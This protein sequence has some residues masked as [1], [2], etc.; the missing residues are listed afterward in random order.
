MKLKSYRKIKDDEGQV[1]IV[2]EAIKP[3]I[4]E[5][6]DVCRDANKYDAEQVIPN[7]SDKKQDPLYKHLE[8]IFKDTRSIVWVIESAQP[9][10]EFSAYAV[11]IFKKMDE[12]KDMFEEEGYLWVNKALGL[13]ENSKTPHWRE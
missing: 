1:W 5:L 9:T 4:E 7:S 8:P 6:Y 10:P 13:D 2:K 12:T 3:D 11:R